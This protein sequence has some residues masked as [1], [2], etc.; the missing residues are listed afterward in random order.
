MF[1]K[2]N[3]VTLAIL[4]VAIH[5]QSLAFDF[6][7]IKYARST[8]FW[9]VEVPCYGGS[10]QYAFEYDLPVGWRFDNN[11]IRIPSKNV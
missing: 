10:G 8:D 7:G 4:I 1:S 9:D 11:R 5:S 3:L 6:R 2:N